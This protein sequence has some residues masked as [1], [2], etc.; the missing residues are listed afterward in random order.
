MVFFAIRSCF[1]RSLVSTGE[2][3]YSQ[4]SQV[5]TVNV[6]TTQTEGGLPVALSVAL[7][8]TLLAY[9]TTADLL[10]SQCMAENRPLFW[11]SRESLISVYG[12]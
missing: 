8:V 12:L 1:G 4:L 10:L 11:G 7:S 6:G 5:P 3:T 2:I 9:V